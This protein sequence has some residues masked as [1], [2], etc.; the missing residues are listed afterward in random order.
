MV[1]LLHLDEAIG[2]ATE[3]LVRSHPRRRLRRRG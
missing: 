3:A 2:N 1:V